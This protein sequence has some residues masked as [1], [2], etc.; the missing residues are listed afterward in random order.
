M[1]TRRKRK[2]APKRKPKCHDHCP[3]KPVFFDGNEIRC[4]NT[5]HAIHFSVRHPTLWQRIKGWF[6]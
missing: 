6:K 4:E 2:A 1:K 5:P 3:G